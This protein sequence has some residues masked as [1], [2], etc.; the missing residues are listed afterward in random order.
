[1]KTGHSKMGYEFYEQS[2]EEEIGGWKCRLEV[3]C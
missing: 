3:L 1:M 2:S